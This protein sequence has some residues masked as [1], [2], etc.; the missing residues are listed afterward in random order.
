M[1]SKITLYEEISHSSISLWDDIAAFYSAYKNN[2][3]D[4]E[5]QKYGDVCVVSLKKY[6]S[7]F[8][9][10]MMYSNSDTYRKANEIL[11][12]TTNMLDLIVSMNQVNILANSQRVDELLRKSQLDINQMILLFRQDLKIDT[13]KFGDNILWNLNR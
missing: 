4:K 3:S 1:T 10:L 11:G 9:K 12:S 13:V 8:G 6:F 7:S 5:K 2:N